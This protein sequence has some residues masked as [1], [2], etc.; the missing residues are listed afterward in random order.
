[1]KAGVLISSFVITASLI[2]SSSISAAGNLE[3]NYQRK[4]IKGS[5]SEIAE[6][7]QKNNVNET[8]YPLQVNSSL[9]K[10]SDTVL[11]DSYAEKLRIK[12]DIPSIKKLIQNSPTQF[13]GYYYDADKGTVVVQITEESESLKKLVRESVKSQD[14][15]EFEVVEFSWADIENAKETI[16]KNVEPGTI[17]ALIPDVENNKL[18]IAFDE[19]AI[20]DEEKVSSLINQ[21]AMLE[22]TTL[23]DSAL[24]V[25]TDDTHYG[26]QFPMGSKIG[27]NYHEVAENSYEYSICTAGYFGIN[28]SNQE[29]LVT[30]GHC[31]PSGTVSA[32][33]QPTWNTATIGDYTFRT[34]S[35]GD[36][37]NASSDAGYITL[38]S[39]YTGRSR[40]PYPSSTDMAMITGVYTSDTPG[41]T[42]Y[43]RG[44]NS[45]TTTSGTISYAN[46]DIYWGDHGYGYKHNEVLA[47][48]YS[49]MGGDSGGPILTDFAYDN[50]LQGWTFDLAGT[51]TGVVTLSSTGSP[52]PAGT[53]KVYEPIWTTYNDLNLTGITIIAAP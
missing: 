25:E 44:A 49:S 3:N 9:D 34:T 21:S 33:Y 36:G 43:L 45:G 4:I 41:D 30:S 37:S 42:I 23:P 39:N 29:V 16:E 17:R 7:T 40:V 53:Y 13:S 51:H 19:D 1:M 24:T 38:N 6:I 12:R 20:V 8:P 31:Q 32:W 11:L 26:S 18:I 52:I 2:F 48:G 10:L 27:G 50:S 46:V 22:F 35:A 28:Q 14:K 5:I 15:V 47:T